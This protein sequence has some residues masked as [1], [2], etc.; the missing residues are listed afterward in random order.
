MSVQRNIE[1][2]SSTYS[3]G[4]KA[5]SITYCDFVFVAADIQYAK[6]IRRNIVSVACVF[7][8]YYLINCRIIGEKVMEHT[9]YAL[10]MS[11]SFVWNIYHSKNYWT[12]YY[13]KCI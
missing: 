12:R 3:R 7:P 13:H 11:T 4:G 1:A 8:P 2:H 6:L 9:V 10:L 5:V